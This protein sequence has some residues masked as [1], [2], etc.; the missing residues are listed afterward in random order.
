MIVVVGDMATQREALEAL[1]PKVIELDVN[2][3]TLPEVEESN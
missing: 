1:G 3:Y 2:G